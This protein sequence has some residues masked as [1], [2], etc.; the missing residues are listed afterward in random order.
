MTMSGLFGQFEAHILDVVL[1]GLSVPG[2][3]MGSNPGNSAASNRA[4]SV[5]APTVMAFQD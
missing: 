5:Y 4:F 2:I 1:D 3:A